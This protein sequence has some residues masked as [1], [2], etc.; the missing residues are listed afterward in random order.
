MIADKE[1]YR[2]ADSD[3]LRFV[4]PFIVRTEKVTDLSTEF[5]APLFL[6][7]DKSG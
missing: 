6:K 5:F 2:K 4:P 7:V 3:D 1:H